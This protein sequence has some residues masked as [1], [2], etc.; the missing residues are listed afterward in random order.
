M[1]NSVTY[2]FARDDEPGVRSAWTFGTLPDAD[3][4]AQVAV[5]GIPSYAVEV[6]QTDAERVALETALGSLA[7]SYDDPNDVPNAE[8]P[9]QEEDTPE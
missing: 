8:W 5:G 4:L 1:R 2:V 3:S 9:I 6:K 7:S